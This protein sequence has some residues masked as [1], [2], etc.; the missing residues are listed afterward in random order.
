MRIKSKVI[1]GILQDELDRNSRMIS[2]Y[3]R[4]LENLPKGSLLIRKINGSVNSYVYLKYREGNKVISKYLGE[5]SVLDLDDLN[6]KLSR[7][8][9]L[10]SLIKK[11]KIEKKDL[12]KLIND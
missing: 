11:L 12:E 10:K 6:Q 7:R 8:K 9:E 4:E 3:E 2:R 5:S 1:S